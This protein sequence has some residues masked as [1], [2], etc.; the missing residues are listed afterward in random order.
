MS[1]TCI[2]MLEAKEKGNADQV[3]GSGSDVTLTFSRCFFL[4]M[5]G[6]DHGAAH[7]GQWQGHRF[8][9]SSNQQTGNS[10]QATAINVVRGAHSSRAG[11]RLASR[12]TVTQP[13]M[14]R[15]IPMCEELIQIYGP[16]NKDLT[17]QKQKQTVAE[18]S[19]VAAIGAGGTNAAEHQT[20]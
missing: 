15:T 8:N 10:K 7:G 14:Q 20:R 18:P 3:T 13:R 12:C 16:F 5:A 4:Q 9:S 6:G 2:R 11:Y 17:H 1:T 19:G